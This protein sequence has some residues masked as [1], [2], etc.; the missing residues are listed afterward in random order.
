MPEDRERFRE[1]IG[2]VGEGLLAAER[3]QIW[4]HV[5]SRPRCVGAR[6]SNDVP[7]GRQRPSNLAVHRVAAV[8][9]RGE[10][11]GGGQEDE[12]GDLVNQLQSA[13]E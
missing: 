8:G 2:I 9:Q 12:I 5:H 3:G 10:T 13:V 11:D 4:R 1:P 6:H 7:A